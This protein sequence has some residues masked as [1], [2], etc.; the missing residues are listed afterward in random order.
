MN[1][2]ANNYSN[3]VR[4]IALA[5]AFTFSSTNL[6]LAG[7]P[8]VPRVVEALGIY[9]N[10]PIDLSSIKV[11]AD[12]GKIQEVY[13]VKGQETGDT[14][15]EEQQKRHQSAP[16]PVSRSPFV[17]L[18][19]DAHAIPEA[20]RNIQKLIQHFQN[21]YG[22]STVGVEG[23][24]TDL[25]AQIFNSFPDKQLLEKTFEEYFE[26]G[27]LNGTA[28][29]AVLSIKNLS[30]NQ[31]IF[32][33]VENWNLYEKGLALYL[34]AVEK[35]PK[36]L[37]GLQAASYRLQGEKEKIYSKELLE[38]DQALEAFKEN[39]TDLVTVLKIL[40][41]RGQ[42]PAGAVPL[43]IQAIL[44]ELAQEG[45]DSSAIER[46]VRGI[47]ERVKEHLLQAT[48]RKPQ[49]YEDPAAWSLK[50]AA[51]NQSY[52][53]FQTSRISPEEFALYLKELLNAG[54]APT[55]KIS[56]RLQHLLK[57]QKRLRDIEGTQFFR[58]F[59]TY[60]KSV[61]ESLFRNNE[62][63]K[64]DAE[65]RRV[66]LL[67]KLAKLELSREDWEEIKTR[68]YR[69]ETSDQRQTGIQ[70]DSL[71][72][73]HFA[74]Y[75]NAENRD[76]AFFGNLLKLM[77]QPKPLV[78]NPRSQV[79]S[80]ALLVAGGFHTQGLAR[81]FKEKGISYV[82]VQPQINQLPISTNYRAQMQGEVSWKDYFEVEQ[83]KVNLYKAFVRGARD[84]LLRGQETRDKGQEIAFPV[85]PVSRPL[86]KAWRDQIIRDLADQNRLEK[87]HDYTQFLD[88]I[89][90]DSRP[91][92]QDA[93]RNSWSTNIDRFITGLHNL[94]SHG[95]LTEQ[96]ILKLLNPAT[97]PTITTA[98]FFPNTWM[99]A[100]KSDG[101]IILSPRLERPP[102]GRM[103]PRAEVPAARSELRSKDGQIQKLQGVY[104][105]L[106]NAKAGEKA[107]IGEM[108]EFVNL[109]AGYFQKS[110]PLPNGNR[111]GE[112]HWLG[113]GENL[114]S[115]SLVVEKR[116]AGRLYYVFSY[117]KEEGGK[118]TVEHYWDQDKQDLIQGVK[119]EFERNLQILKLQDAYKRREKA[120][121][122][123]GEEIGDVSKLVNLKK[124]SFKLSFLLPNGKSLGEQR[125]LGS[126]ENLTSVSLVVEKRKAG[127]LYYVFSYE[128]EEGGK[129]TV[130]H[131]W[132]QDK[133]DLIQGVKL[134]FERNLQ[135][136]KLQDAYKRREKAKVGAGEEI[137]DV[138][139]LV[140]LKKGSFKLSFLL[141]NGKSL[142]EQRRLGSGENLTSVSLVV[143]K[144]KAGRLYYV[145]SYEKEEGG[146][147]TVEHYWDRAKQDLIQGVKLESERDPQIL[148]LQDAYKRIEK[149]KAGKREEIGDIAGLVYLKMGNFQKS[150][151]LP[152]GNRLGEQR[153]LGS[154]GN[155]TSVSL[156]VEKRK[157]GRLYYVFSYE[158][159]EG[160]KGTVEHYWDRAKQDLIQGVKL[161]S[162]RDPQILKLQDAY[163]RIEKAKAGKREEIGDIAGLVYLK[164]G[165]FQKSFPLP[166]GNRL[167]ERR[168]LG[169]GENLTSVSL[170]VEKRKDGRLYYV[171]SYEKEEGRKGTV[172]HYWDRAKQDLIQ[173]VKL[174]SERDLQILKLQDAYKRIEKAKAGKREEIGDIAGLVTLKE[175]K[176][177][178]SF[179]LPNGNRLAEPRRLG[180][181][182]N[183]TSVSL[184]VEKRKDGR[185]YY[186]FSYEK[187]EGRK[188]TVEHY[189]DA[190]K[191]RLVRIGEEIDAGDAIDKYDFTEAV[192]LL[193]NDPLRLVQYLRIYH[194][195]LSPE[196]TDRS[197]AASLRGLR[198]EGVETEELHLDYEERL[199]EPEVTQDVQA[200]HAHSFLLS[201]RTT[202]GTPFI[203]V[204][205]AYTRKIAVRQDG[206]FSAP[207]P[208]PRT[209]ETN[210]FT[211]YAF[212]PESG[213]KSP[214]VFI[215]VDQ[216][217]QKEDA[218][219][220]FLRLLSLKEEKLESIQQNPAR[221]EFLLRSVEQSLLKHFTYDEKAGLR[222]LEEKIGKEKS[223][224][225]KAIL[226]AVLK[227]FRK[228]KD[229]D[230]NLKAGER[231]YFFQK[232]TA[233][234]IQSLMTKGAK[235]LIVANEQ[236]TGK[237][238][239]ALMVMNGKEGVILTPNSVVSTWAEQEDKFIPQANLEVLEGSYAEREERLTNLKRP[240]LVT[241]IEF[242][243]AMNEKK[244]ALLSRPQG[245]LVVD[246]ADYLGS[247]TSQQAKG[248]RQIQADFKL[249]LT[250]TPFKR[251]SQIGEL[252]QFIRPDDSRFSSARAFARAFPA[253]DREAMNALFLL[254]QEH[255]IRIRKR[256]VF[257]TYDPAVSLEKQSDRLP[258]K[259]KISPEETGKFDLHKVQMESILELFTD[260]ETWMRKHKG[261]HESVEDTQYYR[262]REGY[263]S[264][265]E[266][267]RQ[268][269]ND[270]AYI[271][272]PDLESPKHLEMDE[273]VNDELVRQ[274]GQKMLIFTRY[275]AQVEEYKKRYAASY[276]VRTYYGD[277]PQN[278]NGYKVDENGNVLY[279]KV[280]EYKNP[281]LENGKLVE[282]DKE[283]GRPV[284]ALDYERILFQND[285]DSRIMV[286]TYDAG[287]V[288]VTFTAADV[289]VFDDLAQTYRDEYQA[290]D[291][292]HR[293]DNKRKKYKVKYYWLQARYP[294]SFLRNLPK[295]IR[296]QYFNMGTF[297][298][299]QYE[300]LRI[301]ARIF[302]RVMDGVGSEEELGEANQ[303]FMSQ[304][305][306][307]M[308]SQGEA[309]DETPDDEAK[310]E[311]SKTSSRSEIRSERHVSDTAEHSETGRF[312]ERQES[313]TFVVQ[314]SQEPDRS[315]VRTNAREN[316][317]FQGYVLNYS[318]QNFVVSRQQV[319]KIWNAAQNSLDAIYSRFDASE[320][321]GRENFERFFQI[322]W[323]ASP[324]VLD[325]REGEAIP[326]SVSQFA[327]EIGV[328]GLPIAVLD[329]VRVFEQG[330]EDKRQ[331]KLQ[332]LQ[333]LLA[334]DTIYLIYDR[335]G[336]L[337]G[338]VIYA[339]VNG[340]APKPVVQQKIVSEKKPGTGTREPGIKPQAVWQGLFDL[341]G[342]HGQWRRESG[343]TVLAHD[344]L[345]IR[346]GY[347]KAGWS[348]DHPWKSLLED[349]SVTALLEG[350]FKRIHPKNVPGSRSRVLIFR[351]GLDAEGLRQTLIY[352]FEELSSP[353]AIL[354][355]KETFS[356]QR[357]NPVSFQ[358][359]GNEMA[360]PNQPTER[361]FIVNALVELGLTKELKS[362]S[363]VYEAAPVRKK[364]ES[365][366]EGQEKSKI[367]RIPSL[368]DVR[369]LN[370]A[371]RGYQGKDLAKQRQD[372]VLHLNQI[373]SEPGALQRTERKRGEWYPL[374]SREVG[375]GGR[376]SYRLFLYP[377]HERTLVIVGFFH[378][379]K[380][381]KGKAGY[382]YLQ[383]V[384]KSIES[385]QFQN[386]LAL[387]QEGQN[388]LRDEL[389]IQIIRRAEIR[390]AEEVITEVK[391]WLAEESKELGE[392]EV[393]QLIQAAVA[394]LLVEAQGV[395]AGTGTAPVTRGI[396]LRMIVKARE[397]IGKEL[398]FDPSNPSQLSEDSKQQIRVLDK[399][400]KLP[401][402]L[403]KRLVELQSILGKLLAQKHLGLPN[404][405]GQIRKLVRWFKPLSFP[406]QKD[407]KPD[408]QE[409][410]Y[411]ILDEMAHQTLS[412]MIQAR[413]AEQ[414]LSSGEIKEPMKTGDILLDKG[415]GTVYLAESSDQAARWNPLGISKFSEVLTVEEA[416]TKNIKLVSAAPTA[417]AE[418]R[419]ARQEPSTAQDVRPSASRSE[420]R[421]EWEGSPLYLEILDQELRI[422]PLDVVERVDGVSLS[423]DEKTLVEDRLRPIMAKAKSLGD[424][425]MVAFL[426]ALNLESQIKKAE[427][428]D[429]LYGV[430]SHSGKIYLN[431]LLLEAAQKAN[432]LLSNALVSD[433]S[434]EDLR[435]Y[436]EG[437]LHYLDE[438][439]IH[440]FQHEID[441]AAGHFSFDL[442]N[443]KVRD[444]M[445]R[446]AIIKTAAYFNGVV[447]TDQKTRFA[448]IYRYPFSDGSIASVGY[449]TK[450]SM[451]QPTEK[452]FSK[453][454]EITNPP[455]KYYEV[456]L[457]ILNTHFRSEVRQDRN[458]ADT[459]AEV[460]VRR[461]TGKPVSL[462]NLKKAAH[463]TVLLKVEPVT[464]RLEAFREKL[465][466]ESNSA[467]LEVL[468]AQTQQM[469][470][471]VRSKKETLNGGAFAY[472][473]SN[474][475]VREEDW[476]TNFERALRHLSGLVEEVIV[477]AKLDRSAKQRIS[478]VVK[479]FEG[480]KP[481]VKDLT[482]EPI[483]MGDHT[484]S[485][486]VVSGVKNPQDFLNQLDPAYIPIVNIDV[487]AGEDP[488]I[489][490][491]V[492]L[493]QMTIAL[494]VADYVRDDAAKAKVLQNPALLFEQY[495]DLFPGFQD[496]VVQGEGGYLKIS[497]TVVREFLAEMTARA[498]IRKSA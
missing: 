498:E 360:E 427:L 184:V 147:G 385:R 59:E 56:D 183:L 455:F 395:D 10:P 274:P 4:A 80:P 6:A 411:E 24:A 491:F 73:A 233:Y 368:Y 23:A 215:Q 206:S 417:R 62:E 119:L 54:A 376:A 437:V 163:K 118:G 53:E 172:E 460:F 281:V 451:L 191:E 456:L 72:A 117:E 402:L 134:E 464:Q 304:R 475:S 435:R 465:E 41:T 120:K 96:N 50:L 308:F 140:N 271:G 392:A 52:Q 269:M 149:A 93:F 448:A 450:R 178:K 104:K 489:S 297:D 495:P 243:R 325:P 384:K 78:F 356:F 136:L 357:W 189:W 284:R 55:I 309:E 272:R 33:G 21:Q 143:E 63:R 409:M 296:E 97:I 404:L 302:H 363:I 262:Y 138:S 187:E 483:F 185:L 27:E 30:R 207:I 449:T 334:I 3:A 375:Q 224:A 386:E 44:D 348:R 282:T 194:P 22:I 255:T 327:R 75:K 254:M 458:L 86:L 211:V 256:D 39:Q 345:L 349:T 152:N 306:P 150:F 453:E 234:E 423:E 431:V 218:E 336:A 108:S 488:L 472:F 2:K 8:V 265:R 146:K 263:F 359:H 130:E 102:F 166:N 467:S 161:E 490:E 241:N 69:P 428:G 280:D 205:G 31:T 396:N 318:G 439:L 487:P 142:G 369:F 101:K 313:Q 398:G 221:Y 113:S 156:V 209:G 412:E 228:I 462:S 225:Q 107:E 151:P 112:R 250:A 493:A 12:I 169:S 244:A 330:L 248:T 433:A 422:H 253:E 198:G 219:E 342:Q 466:G 362:G 424:E 481:S 480:I 17:V 9:L 261:G 214:V 400:L 240:Q 74:F 316:E 137:G 45:A 5:T 331:E 358:R 87:A 126:G 389:K 446:S 195:E 76:Q 469:I 289:V 380:L 157:A 14:R 332:T 485:G 204:T 229:M 353:P 177:Q 90:Q 492:L 95:R 470:D 406:D 426:K 154:G 445:E 294:E 410:L 429:D 116:K 326:S 89:I 36:I 19:Q 341:I 51:F 372:I 277:L 237:T 202:I 171:F 110:F 463:T 461:L 473:I 127:R 383:G 328:G 340:G 165:S 444:E 192:A 486:V 346:E 100:R 190:V 226:E 482:Q 366:N 125:R 182:E 231:L 374:L 109:K 28:A 335:A 199:A 111:L 144:R 213:E 200:T 305:M 364:T 497:N 216:T 43:S 25:D 141:P 175:G 61:K 337:A 128:K 236:G 135:I 279:Y 179:L 333:E 413:L 401:A 222:Y 124:G 324:R 351:E 37:E 338:F 270:P 15:Q 159:E 350:L 129:G 303:H 371:I 188:G 208:L 7:P 418:L 416:K 407:L 1:H 393:Y 494:L 48:G 484:H 434:S 307:F 114:T 425:E 312:G 268:L 106:E 82:I 355:E 288:G 94:E 251:I 329:P 67:E 257:E 245:L 264:K 290:E 266:A 49:D 479:K 167:G 186:V 370:A 299:V 414:E 115:V 34:E 321:P 193:G 18:I 203:Q 273:I 315:E 320:R 292:A 394:S 339:F 162:E 64:L 367:V 13:G 145:F 343:K 443:P 196:E 170:V 436:Y 217:G 246:E 298:Q 440:E 32:H 347:L 176:F 267:L 403:D 452:D 283:H 99:G 310:E 181:G 379:D 180:S 155:L 377:F 352:L 397:I 344:L 79:S 42:S 98:S 259:E 60:A 249:L 468:K 432:D 354:T 471:V 459:A 71:W 399:E 365:V 11:P 322:L 16:R 447:I 286:A 258:A 275:R 477:P 26:R 295:D 227:K 235:G 373:L 68:D 103:K 168:W 65:S 319:R 388:Y 174:E 317:G 223:K 197:A 314:G 378:K 91:K 301:L 133:Q 210:E 285:P 430:E 160:G 252:L 35:E 496:R 457:K 260:P 29:A 421:S 454:R 131:Y 323:E 300:N 173:G 311:K 442:Q 212:D 132:D 40:Q 238:V 122:G 405:M 242:T 148:K 391:K 220:A 478:D 88:E 83:G 47:A 474:D 57:N 247:K 81:Q 70:D 438:T 287:A 387:P 153:R 164:S 441:F 420:L 84:R 291:R 419:L 293:I 105:K 85:S 58:D 158:K 92:T 408:L 390:N 20:Q 276:G 232:Y 121:V 230:F 123:A 46:E 476:A 239:I 38:I 66:E 77:A 278:A 201:G 382:R 139:K 415:T 381:E 361:N